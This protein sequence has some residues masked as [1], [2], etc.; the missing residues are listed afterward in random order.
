MKP[1]DDYLPY[2]LNRAG[3]RIAGAFTSVVRDYGLTLPMWR[4][5]AALNEADGRR[6]GELALRTSIDQSTLSRVVDALERRGLVRRARQDADARGVAVH[7]GEAG[8][9]LTAKIVPIALHYETVALAG[10][11]GPQAKLLKRMLTQLYR[12]MDALDAERA[13]EARKAG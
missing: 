7:A 10:F 8:R 4:V 1:L 9:A 2:L 6:M 5:L 3:A 12:N 11:S 13:A